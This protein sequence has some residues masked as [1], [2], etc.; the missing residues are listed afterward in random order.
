MMDR[1]AVRPRVVL[2]CIRSVQP[3]FINSVLRSLDGLPITFLVV[4]SK[5]RVDNQDGDVEFM[6]GGWWDPRKRRTEPSN[7]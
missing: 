2:T 7:N 3:L 1:S 6:R 5:L 4:A